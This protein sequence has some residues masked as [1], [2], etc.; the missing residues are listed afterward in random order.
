MQ[1]SLIFPQPWELRGAP[2]SRVIAVL[3]GKERPAAIITYGPLIVRPDEPES[4]ISQSVMS[5]IPQG[6]RVQRKTQ[7]AQK[8]RDGWPLHLVEAE[9]VGA[10]EELIECRL[11]VFYYFLEHAAFAM[12]RVVDRAALAAQGPALLAILASAR[13]SWRGAPVCLAEVWDLEPKEQRPR[14]PAQPPVS[15]REALTA[16][17]AEIDHALAGELTATL[18]LRRG[19]LL[20]ELARAAEALAAFRA[21]LQL[22]PAALAAH[23]HAAVALAELGRP[24]EAIAE[25]QAALKLAPRFIDAHYNIGQ[26]HFNQ[27]D[28]GAA[29]VA[30][31]TA[32]ALDPSELASL[33]K[34]I[35]CLYALGRFA[36]GQ[37]A[38]RSLRARVAAGDDQRAQLLTEYV[39]DQFAGDGFFV[40]ALETLKTSGAVDTLLTF[41]AVD[42]H[43]HPLSVT[44]LVETSELARSAGT[45]YVL[46]LQAQKSYRVIGTAK[47]LPD[48]ADL[49][50]EVLSV[51][52]DALKTLS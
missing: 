26:A 39:Y 15:T 30:F 1:L 33:R 25:W 38:R 17:L 21:A 7:L 28:F 47:Q 14:V 3:P 19:L 8:T 2:G 36:D 12:V 46:A 34:V 44:V 29:L 48:Y 27:K 4:W 20:L 5:D 22:D 18:H 32:C 31:E 6:L 11:C 23:H 10:G 52:A 51:I 24:S 50:E 43:D 13:P 40:H 9:L 42:A 45:P 16:A 35:Q 37:A 49:K 41:R